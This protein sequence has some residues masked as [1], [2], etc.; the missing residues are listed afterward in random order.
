LRNIRVWNLPVA[1]EA[2]VADKGVLGAGLTV[3]ARLAKLINALRLSVAALLVR[4]C[5]QGETGKSK[6]D[7]GLEKHVG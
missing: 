1:T 7:E 2:V 5:C 4:R 3:Q 6:S